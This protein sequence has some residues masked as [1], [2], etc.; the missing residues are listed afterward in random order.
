MTNND[1]SLPTT[2]LTPEQHRILTTLDVAAALRMNPK[3]SRIVDP[4]LVLAEL[5]IA[6]LLTAGVF[7][8]SE[9]A[10]SV[11]WLA[12]HGGLPV[13]ANQPEIKS[14]HSSASCCLNWKKSAT[15]RPGRPLR[16]HRQPFLDFQWHRT[17]APK[18]R[19][20]SSGGPSPRS[21]GASRSPG[22]A[23][24]CRRAELV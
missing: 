8:R 21:Q 9:I 2:P 1:S 11:E 12:Q 16:Q 24:S 17:T 7:H 3:R 10:I 15:P 13:F 23:F 18:A 14:S 19:P 6:R 5:H 4:Y 22:L 20:I